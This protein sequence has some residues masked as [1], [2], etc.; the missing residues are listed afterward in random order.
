M[1]WLCGLSV[2]MP[3]S[4]PETLSTTTCVAHVGFSI[5]MLKA[6]KDVFQE[7]AKATTVVIRN[8]PDHINSQSAALEWLQ[9]TGDLRGYDFFLFFPKPR[10]MKPGKL[11]YP[12]P[13]F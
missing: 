9:A 1:S 13:L 8:L 11:S 6:K 4:L 12:I 10:T 7:H 3:T 2:A 5:A